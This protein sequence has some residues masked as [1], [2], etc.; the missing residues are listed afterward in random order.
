LILT[1]VSHDVF[2]DDHQVV[3]Q[4]T[5]GNREAT[6]THQIGRHTNCAHDH[7]RDH[8]ANTVAKI[9]NRTEPK[10]PRKLIF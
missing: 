6:Q 8:A 9:E 3:D 4:H 5:D 1:E 2:D 10:I 7:Q